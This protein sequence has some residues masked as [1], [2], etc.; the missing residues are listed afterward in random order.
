[1]NEVM[2]DT[3]Q[4]AIKEALCIYYSK[5]VQGIVNVIFIDVMDNFDISRYKD[6]D[7]VYIKRLL[8]SDCGVKLKDIRPGEYDEY[9]YIV[10]VVNEE[11]PYM[12]EE[13]LEDLGEMKVLRGVNIYV[14][15]KYFDFSK[16]MD[17]LIEYKEY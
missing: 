2:K 11:C 3:Y 9:H 4:K 5:E 8:T 7:K 10:E 15:A 12:I 17:E 14:N 13:V 16:F 1:M 6:N